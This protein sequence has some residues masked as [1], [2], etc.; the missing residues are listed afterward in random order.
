MTILWADVGELRRDAERA[1]QIH[2]ETFNREKNGIDENQ[3]TPILENFHTPADDGALDPNEAPEDEDTAEELHRH[4]PRERPFSVAALVRRA[5]EGLGHPGNERLARILKDAKASTEAINLAKNLTCSVC[6]KHAATRPARRAAPPKQLH[7]NQIVGV[8]TIYL[9]DHGGKRRMALNI[10][11]WASRFQMMIPLAGHT[12]GAA[13]RAYLQ[14]VRLFGP[15]EK[16]YTDLGREF[17]G[18]FEIGAEQDSTFI[19]PSSL[20]MPTQRSITER[21]GRS[22][23]EVLTRTM[24]QVACSTHEEWLNVV[25]VVNMTCNRLMNKSGFSPTSPGIHSSNSWRPSYWRRKRPGNYES[26]GR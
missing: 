15:P 10:V 21:A 11:D 8:D 16:L 6:E 19:E 1:Q 24:M 17:K 18:A 20:E 12:P 2:D 13:R 22:F 23:K 7:V 25:D 5:H 26:S 4:L 9:P 14:W 3:T